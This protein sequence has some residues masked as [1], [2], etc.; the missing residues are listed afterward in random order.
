M[1]PSSVSFTNLNAVRVGTFSGGK[2]EDKLSFSD[3]G[4]KG[5]GV[6]QILSFYFSFLTVKQ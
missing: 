1:V 5:A 2:K 6:K 4:E 3:E